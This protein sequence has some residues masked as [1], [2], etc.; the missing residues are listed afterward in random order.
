VGE[1]RVVAVNSRVG[2]GVSVGGRCVK[3]ETRVGDS[4]VISAGWNGVGVSEASGFGVTSTS[5]GEIPSAV[6]REQAVVNQSRSANRS[7]SF[8][9][10]L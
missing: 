1:A 10:L 9:A 8:I 5:P 3:V 6:G 7:V 4:G 2:S